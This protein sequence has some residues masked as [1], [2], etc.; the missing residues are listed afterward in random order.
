MYRNILYLDGTPINI[1]I[2][3]EVLGREEEEEPADEQAIRPRADNTVGDGLI[4]IV[5]ML[6]ENKPMSNAHNDV[7]PHAHKMYKPGDRH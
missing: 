5:T 3:G 4:E 2:G 6:K 7:P 1:G